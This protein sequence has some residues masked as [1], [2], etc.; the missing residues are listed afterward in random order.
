MG[1]GSLGSDWLERG[2]SNESADARRL[3]IAAFRH[4]EGWEFVVG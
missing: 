2:A 3:H 1:D 4:F